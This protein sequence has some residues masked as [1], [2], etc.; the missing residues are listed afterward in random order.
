MTVECN[1]CSA[2]FSLEKEGGVEGYFGV[3]LVR[4][5]P[6]C[7]ASMFDMVEQLTEPDDESEVH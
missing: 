4:F 6:F 7:L 5:C 1:V 2:D 3:L